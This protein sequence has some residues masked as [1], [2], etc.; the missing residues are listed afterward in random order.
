MTFLAWSQCLQWQVFVY[1]DLSIFC[2][3]FKKYSFGN[4]SVTKKKKKE[5]KFKTFCVPR[6]VYAMGWTFWKKRIKAGGDKNL[7]ARIT[8][9]SLDYI[10]IFSYGKIK[11]FISLYH[12][13]PC[14]S[15]ST[16]VSFNFLW[17]PNWHRKKGRLKKRK[18]K[19]SYERPLDFFHTFLFS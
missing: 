6:H 1:F 12:S 19:S 9:G 4:H 3:H 11:F 5:K 8:E 17:R 16:R 14:R 15:F 18:E 7:P 13:D 2:F 10:C